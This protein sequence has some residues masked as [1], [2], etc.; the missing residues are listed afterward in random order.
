MGPTRAADRRAHTLASNTL[1]HQGN[2]GHPG[3][4]LR[5]SRD[6]GTRRDDVRSAIRGRLRCVKR[7]HGA[8]TIAESASWRMIVNSA[9]QFKE[10]TPRRGRILAATR[11]VVCLAIRVDPVAIN[12]PGQAQLRPFTARPMAIF[13][14]V[15]AGVLPVRPSPPPSAP[16][17]VGGSTRRAH[18]SAPERGRASWAHLGRVERCAGAGARRWLGRR[19]RAPYAASPAGRA[20]GPGRPL[21]GRRPQHVRWSIRPRRVSRSGYGSAWRGRPVRGAP[22]GSPRA[23]RPPPHRQDRR[24]GPARSHLWGKIRRA[25]VVRLTP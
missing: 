13:G 2:T 4:P 9:G 6:V 7:H 20:P 18:W 3:R 21:P 12:A 16:R 15:N 25:G 5:R 11:A 10:A 8:F 22:A 24:S 14:A 1:A 19:Y 17:T 23:R